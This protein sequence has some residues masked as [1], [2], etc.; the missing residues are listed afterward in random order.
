MIIQEEI[1]KKFPSWVSIMEYR[2]II[3]FA[4]G[5]TAK[6]QVMLDFLYQMYQETYFKIEDQPDGEMVL[7]AACEEVSEMSGMKRIDPFHNQYLNFIDQHINEVEFSP[8]RFY[9]FKPQDL[10]YGFEAN[11]PKIR[12]SFR[13]LLNPLPAECIL[14]VV[15]NNALE[16][17]LK[18]VR[19]IANYQE[20][21]IG[22]LSIMEVNTMFDDEMESNTNTKAELNKESEEDCLPESLTRKFNETVNIGQNIRIVR[23]TD[24]QLSSSMFKHLAEE[25]NGCSRLEELKFHSADGIPPELGEVLS[26]ARSLKRV[27]VVWCNMPESVSQHILKG[28][29]HCSEL[30][31]VRLTGNK[32]SSCMESFLNRHFDFLTKLDISRTELGKEDI[33]SLSQAFRQ[34]KLPQLHE[35]DL[36]YNNLEGKMTVLFGKASVK[37]SPNYNSIET[38]KL[39][40]KKLSA[41]D[42]IYL[43]QIMRIH[44]LPAL[45]DLDLSD[46]CL[47]HCI[48]EMMTGMVE[49][50]SLESLNLAGTELAKDDLHI[51]SDTLKTGKLP[52]LQE[53]NLQRNNL[54]RGQNDVEDLIYTCMRKL[55]IEEMAKQVIKDDT[56]HVYLQNNNF[57][58]TFFENMERECRGTNIY[59]GKKRSRW[60][61]YCSILGEDGPL[62]VVASAIGSILFPKGRGNSAEAGPSALSAATQRFVHKQRSVDFTTAKITSRANI[63]KY[64]TAD[65]DGLLT[66]SAQML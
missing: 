21:S 65:D 16:F 24:C 5:L 40:C 15:G 20:V 57:S 9:V 31:T 2:E 12:L 56:L 13:E 43:S 48:G 42:T 46:N 25:L 23:I 59:L 34:S 45:K 52:H 62:S 44:N 11:L 30:N 51:L 37:Y 63:K 66:K 19:V 6:S 55:T 4:C 32:L 26:T 29:S 35:L 36:S 61:P 10:C 53:L 8:S 39:T 60:C 54:H 33:I 49:L 58:P 50:T 38:L 27:A 14:H 17:C 41:E 1:R 22:G 3:L 7:I 18:A 64:Q 28:L 47:T